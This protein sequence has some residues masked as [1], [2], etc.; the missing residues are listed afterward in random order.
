MKLNFLTVAIPAL[1]AAGMANAVE[2]Y[3]KDGNK[4]D[5]YGRIKGSNYIS[6]GNKDDIDTEKSGDRTNARLGIRGET[7]IAD[8]LVGYGR[9]EWQ[10]N[11]SHGDTG[12]N[13]RYTYAGFR[14]GDYGS[15]DY[16]KND[17]IVRDIFSYTDVLPEFGADSDHISGLGRASLLG[18]REAA[19]I[20]YRNSDFFGLV[21]GLRFGLQYKDKD[22]SYEADNIPGAL[23]TQATVM[24]DTKARE[25]YGLSL[26]YDILDSGLTVGGAYARAAGK[27]NTY[28]FG[29]K[30][31][32]DSLYVAALYSHTKYNSDLKFS[33]FEI[34]AQYGFDLEIGRITP[35]IAYLQGKVKTT[36]GSEDIQQYVDLGLTYDFNRNMSAVID[37]KINLVEDMKDVLGLGLIY[38]F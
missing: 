36:S 11:V 19:V 12:L 8:N 34:V 27:A 15:I 37:Y 24:L 25:S 28:A 9:A 10:K 29:V 18:S 38:R 13:T 4:V 5:L 1:L 33:L 30:Y 2:V 3:N 21:D 16:G 6:I 23:P 26:D 22:H 20:T 7:E 17:G 32:A 35:S 31:D 14:F